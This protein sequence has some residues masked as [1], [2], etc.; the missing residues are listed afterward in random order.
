MRPTDPEHDPVVRELRERIT[1]VDHAIL[2]AANA[3]LEL[4]RRL[5]EHKLA[6]GWDFLDPGREERLLD[7]LAKDNPGPLGDEAV[8]QLFTDLLA[9]TKREIDG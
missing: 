8:R 4:V 5:R 1:E 3:R 2:E 9:L 6:Q 7:A